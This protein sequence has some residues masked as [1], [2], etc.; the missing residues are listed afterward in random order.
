MDI[1]ETLGLGHRVSNCSAQIC[2]KYRQIRETLGSHFAGGAH[3]A[4]S[5][6]TSGQGKCCRGA[7]G[8]QG[9]RQLD[10]QGAAHRDWGVWMWLLCLV[11]FCECGLLYILQRCVCHGFE[12][13]RVKRHSSSILLY[14]DRLL[15]RQVR[16]ETIQIP[17]SHKCKNVNTR[18]STS[19]RIEF[20]S[21]YIPEKL[22]KDQF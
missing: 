15:T 13:H 12:K 21:K 20:L 7:A 19:M 5:C 16:K 6:L 8:G 2:Q 18:F 11:W 10:G 1:A 4:A 9:G 3:A 22:V 17:F 14:Y